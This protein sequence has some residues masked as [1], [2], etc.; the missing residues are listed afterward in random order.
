MV[1]SPGTPI[2]KNCPIRN[3]CNG[4]IC[5][6]NGAGKVI[7]PIF[8]ELKKEEIKSL[9]TCIQENWFWILTSNLL[10]CRIR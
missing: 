9:E 2:M 7:S 10:L 8:K 3:I 5:G 4:K 1:N 6:V